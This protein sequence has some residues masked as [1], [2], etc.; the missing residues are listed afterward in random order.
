MERPT[1]GIHRIAGRRIYNNL[2]MV[3]MELPLQSEAAPVLVVSQRPLAVAG[4]ALAVVGLL[5][6]ICAPAFLE[7]QAAPPNDLPHVLAESAHN[8]KHHLAY[9]DIQV[10]PQQ[11]ISLKTI[12][13]AG[14][15]LVGFLGAAV[16][17]ASW[18]RREKSRWSSVAIAAGLTAIAWNYFVLA[19]VAAVA[20]FLMAWIISNFHK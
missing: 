4:L 17:T 7:A 20:L 6:A 8:I 5:T 10:D 2:P 9:K 14:G 19:A 12:L 3:C 18:M 13:M 1:W 11:A 15:G 16:G